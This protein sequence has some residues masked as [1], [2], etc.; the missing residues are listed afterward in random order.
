LAWA[1]A[2]SFWLVVCTYPTGEDAFSAWPY[3]LGM[4]AAAMVA[5][6]ALVRRDPLGLRRHVEPTAPAGAGVR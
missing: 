2:C 3:Q 1:V 5:A 6:T 4:V